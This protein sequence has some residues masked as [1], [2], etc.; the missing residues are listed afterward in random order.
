MVKHWVCLSFECYR[1]REAELFDV[2]GGC[3]SIE[4]GSVQLCPLYFNP[5]RDLN[6]FCG[7][8]SEVTD[9]IGEIVYFG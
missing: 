4:L 3:A 7:C 2:A 9:R 6:I 5:V 1:L 8:R